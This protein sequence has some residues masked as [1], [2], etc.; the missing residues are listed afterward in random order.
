[1]TTNTQTQTGIA[2]SAPDP[3]RFG[4]FKR[5]DGG[6]PPTMRTA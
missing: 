3:Y 2:A 6:G 1:M 5:R 4:E